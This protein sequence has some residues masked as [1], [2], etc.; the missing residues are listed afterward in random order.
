MAS[1]F[2]SVNTKFLSVLGCSDCLSFYFFVLQWMLWSL[3]RPP[4]PGQSHFFCQLLEMLVAD[5]SQLMPVL[6]E[7]PLTEENPYVRGQGCAP[8]SEQL[9]SNSWLL[10]GKMS[11]HQGSVWGHCEGPPQL[12][13]SSLDWV[14]HPIFSL[15]SSFAHFSSLPPSTGM[16]LTAI[17]S[18]I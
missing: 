2:Y 14:E 6:Q 17:P 12:W 8:T 9:V 15:S 4:S 1:H 13:S 11:L 18:S 16:D 5:S 3:S 7:S 10:E